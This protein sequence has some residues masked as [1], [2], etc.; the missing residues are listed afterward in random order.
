MERQE[1]KGAAC[2]QQL[3][4]E[5]LGGARSTGE[6]GSLCN[7]VFVQCKLKEALLAAEMSR[8]LCSMNVVPL[9][10]HYCEQLAAA[11]DAANSL[12]EIMEEGFAA[13]GRWSFF[14]TLGCS[15]LALNKQ[16][17]IL[18]QYTHT[19][20]HRHGHIEAAVREVERTQQVCPG[21][22]ICKAVLF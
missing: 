15:Q 5:D 11:A 6:P 16:N 4:I 3:V 12:L 1:Q 18:T 17:V 8:L 2:E 9:R 7:V 20:R 21:S 22:I 14:S 10:V 13:S 19:L